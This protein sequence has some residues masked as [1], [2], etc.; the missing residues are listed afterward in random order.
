LTCASLYQESSMVLMIDSKYLCSP[1]F[2]TF[3]PAKF[4]AQATL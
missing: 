2:D 4:L 3:S 1:F